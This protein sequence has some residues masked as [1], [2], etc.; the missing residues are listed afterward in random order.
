MSDSFAKEFGLELS[1]FLLVVDIF[2]TASRCSCG[3]SAFPFSSTG[4][5][6]AFLFLNGDCCLIGLEAF[7]LQ[8][9]QIP[10]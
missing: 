7:P 4:H 2:A 8:L 5:H 3:S 10:H 9:L 6:Y 1:D